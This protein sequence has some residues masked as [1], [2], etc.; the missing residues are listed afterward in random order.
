M[1][2]I[3]KSILNNYTPETG[4]HIFNCG[5]SGESALGGGDLIICMSNLN[6]QSGSYFLNT[7]IYMLCASLLHNRIMSLDGSVMIVASRLLHSS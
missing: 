4:E 6:L 7:V 5:K 2:G 3:N 1:D